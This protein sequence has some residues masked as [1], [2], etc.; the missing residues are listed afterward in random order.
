MDAPPLFIG[1]VNVTVAWP[2]PATADTLVGA[3]G[4]VAG[5]TE[6]DALEAVLVPAEFVA[7]TVNVYAVPFESPVTMSGDE[8]PVAVNPPV[9]E[10]T[11]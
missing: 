6:F 9:F 7:V 4:T 2:S 8:P 3:F 10:V 1:G 5:V 11:V